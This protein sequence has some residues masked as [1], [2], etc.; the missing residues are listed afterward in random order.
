MPKPFRFGVQS[1]NATS[2]E[3]WA[4]QAQKA[5]SLGYSTFSVAD[6]ILGPGGALTRANH[7]VQNVAAIPAMAFAAAAER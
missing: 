2:G 3:D 1:F 5:E 4:G 6:H 7:P